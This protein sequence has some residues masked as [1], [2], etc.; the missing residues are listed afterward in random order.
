ME[1]CNTLTQLI[2]TFAIVA[3]TLQSLYEAIK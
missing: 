3:Y 1:I 2:L